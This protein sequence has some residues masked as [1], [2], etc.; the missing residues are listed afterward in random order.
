MPLPISPENQPQTVSLQARWVFPVGAEP[1]ENGVIE[2][3]QGQIVDLHQQQDPA[4]IDLGNV[5]IIPGLVN[6]H[7][8][9]E[10]SDL[11]KPLAPTASFA[12]W[13]QA[14]ITHRQQ[15]RATSQEILLQ[16]L[17]EST[18]GGTTLIGDIVASGWNAD[19]CGKP[20]PSIV[21]FRELIGLLPEQQA[22]Q[23]VAAKEHLD[24]IQKICQKEISSDIIA[25]L[26]PHAPYS[27]HLDLLQ[28]ITQL[29]ADKN[30]PVAMHLAE[31]A[32][33]IEL[34]KNG[35][36]HLVEMLKQFALWRDDL[37]PTK[38]RPLD[39]LKIVEAAP[40]ALII[41]GNYLSPEEIN[42]LADHPQMTTIYCPR[43]HTH[44]G[45]PPHPWLR[46]LEKGAKVSLGTDSRASNPD[47]SIWQELLFLNR[48]YPHFDK[49]L[50]LELGTY[51]GAVALGL[52]QQTG[53]LVAGKNAD[54]A[55]VSLSETNRS[56]PYEILF[57]SNNKTVA[58]MSKGVWLHLDT[59]NGNDH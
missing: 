20:H 22:E 36:G 1:L 35:S 53:T 2:I 8:H 42:Y 55:V 56:H 54:L 58:T 27:V 26:S 18:S 51:N 44:F 28:K 43:T 11:S 40:R 52:E 49:S 17:Q 30:V 38:T 9:L 50:L 16:G 48:E 7:T 13:I 3:E 4:A 34:L 31:T 12:H 33:E 45:H 15:P 10:L 32:E 25:G 59:T 46:L 6:C 29:A 5:A 19:C 57:Q 41:H 39:Y 23:M 37:F 21:A 24:H 47:L 14:V